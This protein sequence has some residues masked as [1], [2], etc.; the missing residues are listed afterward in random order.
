MK[1]FKSMPIVRQDAI[2]NAGFACF[3]AASYKK[4]ALDD[5]A[6][7]SGVPKGTIL[8]QFGTKKG[9][10][11]YLYRRACDEI[12]AE[13]RPGTDDFFESV[14][15]A[16]EI[17]MCV[18]R[19]RPGIFDFMRR[20][21]TEEDTQL[22]AEVTGENAAE[23]AGALD[24]LM[25]DVDFSR[26]RADIDPDRAMRVVKLVADGCLRDMRGKGDD[27]RFAVELTAN[28]DFLKSLMYREAFLV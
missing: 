27:K 20:V 8:Y 1:R 4:T 12:K 17:K 10:Y 5:V 22:H 25:K 7:L 16:S 2:I 14:L 26:F 6:A 24:K 11:A 18:E 28:L 15:I 9:L 19:S 23:V 13:L 3:G 21:M